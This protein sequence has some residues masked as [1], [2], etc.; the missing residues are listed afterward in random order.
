MWHLKLCCQCLGRVSVHSD[1]W[2][3]YYIKSISCRDRAYFSVKLSWKY[4][5]MFCCWG[6]VQKWDPWFSDK[7]PCPEFSGRRGGDINVQHDDGVL[8]RGDPGPDQ[9][10]RHCR[11]GAAAAD[12]HCRPRLG[13]GR[14]QPPTVRGR[15]PGAPQPRQGCHPRVHPP[16]L[17]ASS[18]RLQVN[19]KT[20]TA[21]LFTL[22]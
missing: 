6:R 18:H 13:Q 5:D 20:Y 3:D 15:Q 9:D 2:P 12:L 17:Q 22:L 14:S 8:H 10:C 21:D 11:L 16:S 1:R 7:V 19:D 4:S